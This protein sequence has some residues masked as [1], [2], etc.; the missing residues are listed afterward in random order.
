MC[1]F[2]QINYTL[3]AESE[4]KD[5]LR[6]THKELIEDL[7]V[8]RTNLLDLL[9]EKDVISISDNETIKRQ[10]TRK[11][12][13][14]FLLNI[15]GRYDTKKRNT[16]VECLKPDFQ[17]L[18]QSIS[19]YHH[20]MNLPIERNQSCLCCKIVETVDVECVI[21]DL[22]VDGIIEDQIY[23]ELI[24]QKSQNKKKCWDKILSN[25]RIASLKGIVC[26][27]KALRRKYSYIA[28]D[29]EKKHKKSDV[30]Q[31]NC[32]DTKS[33]RVYCENNQVPHHNDQET[34]TKEIYRDS[35]IRHSTSIKDINVNSLFDSGHLPHIFVPVV[36]QN[37]FLISEETRQ[38]E[39]YDGDRSVEDSEE[40]RYK[41]VY[42]GDRSV[43]DSGRNN[44]PMNARNKETG[45]NDTYDNAFSLA[46]NEDFT[47]VPSTYNVCD[48]EKSNCCASKGNANCSN[49]T[50][51]G[52][53][54]CVANE[55]GHLRLDQYNQE[56]GTEPHDT[57]SSKYEQ[58]DMEDIDHTTGENIHAFL[59]LKRETSCR[60]L[61][62][63][64]SEDMA[65]N[66]RVGIKKTGFARAAIKKRAYSV[67]DTRYVT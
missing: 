34:H 1:N 24:N 38:K 9:V 8:E 21:D 59:P 4:I 53:L 47:N 56:S 44:V 42:D 26:F 60:T 20:Y 14:R 15:V 62:T 31:C 35:L 12:K 49:G 45:S 7:D 13:N 10:T 67:G 30:L 51:T 6:G 50:D 19:D 3:F 46:I 28:R 37:T 29:V 52:H 55:K 17:H 63:C 2:S 43:E 58:C 36:R 33:K 57:S 48:S 22:F 65:R 23:G 61:T 16:F 40:T 32:D 41:E 64:V 18:H 5:A 66:L 11:D 25:V 54:T 27:T 39:V